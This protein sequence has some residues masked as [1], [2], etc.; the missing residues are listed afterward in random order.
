MKRVTGFTLVELIITIVILSILAIVAIPRFINASDEAQIN[1]L[2]AIASAFEQI[3]NDAQI[4]WEVAGQPS[5]SINSRPQILYDLKLVMI[6][7]ETGFPVGAGGLPSSFMGFT[8]RAL[9]GKITIFD[10]IN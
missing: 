4:K 2:K 1:Q 3:V 5:G 10:F 6:D 9:T 7:G 8:Y